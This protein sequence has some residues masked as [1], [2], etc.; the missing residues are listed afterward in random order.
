MIRIAHVVN[1]VDAKPPSDLVT[2]Q[3]FCYKSMTD[4]RRLAKKIVEVDLCAVYY[5]EDECMVPD[6]FRKLR[7]LG[8]SIGNMRNFTVKRKL[9]LFRDILD[10]VYHES[11]AD[12]I[13][14]TNCDIILMPHFYQFVVRLIEKG[15]ESIIINKRCV[16]AIYRDVKDLPEVLSEIGT[17]HNGYDCFIYPRDKYKHFVIGDIC[18]GTPWSETTLAVSMAAYC[19]L[20]VLR[21]A[22]VTKH[23]GDSRTWL[24][25]NLTDYRLHNAEQFA[26]VVF[27]IAEDK[28]DILKDSVVR[29]MAF[30]MKYEI[31]PHW[32]QEC[33]DLCG[34][35]TALR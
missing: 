18:M 19:N 12:Y 33:H 14:Q 7:P 25:A 3:P 26:K 2:A 23:I 4:A 9:P 16:P 15:S 32:C 31:K 17:P 21:N 1:P 11:D 35:T 30:K 6:G 22:I 24:A 27:K 34:L 29:W 28:P 10:R 8:N 20:T 13:I 5:P